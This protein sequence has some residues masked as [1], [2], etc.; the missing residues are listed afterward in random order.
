M[1]ENRPPIGDNELSEKD[2]QML[3]DPGDVVHEQIEPEKPMKFRACE[4]DWRNS[5]NAKQ[6][7]EALESEY[8]SMP[9]EMRLL[10]EATDATAMA[11][12]H[13]LVINSSFPEDFMKP[14]PFEDKSIDLKKIQ[15]KAYESSSQYDHIFNGYHPHGK[16]GFT[17]AWPKVLD[18]VRTL[19]TLDNFKG[20]NKEQMKLAVERIVDALGKKGIRAKGIVDILQYGPTYLVVLNDV[21]WRIIEQENLAFYLGG[22]M[23]TSEANLHHKNGGTI[24]AHEFEHMVNDRS[25]R[26]WSQRKRSEGG[27]K[28]DRMIRALKSELDAWLVT[29][30]L[31]TDLSTV[32]DTLRTYYLPTWKEKYGEESEKSFDDFFARAADMKP[33]IIGT[34]LEMGLDPSNLSAYN[35]CLR[36]FISSLPDRKATIGMLGQ[37]KKTGVYEAGEKALAQAA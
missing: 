36:T 33:Y 12:Y 20:L 10:A 27:E 15:E 2:Q 6:D 17:N 7:K 1:Q 9:L 8:E 3:V 26:S 28:T 23:F 13:R 16:H 14:R 19:N 37:I 30:P 35:L 22:F 11:V 34:M 4:P 5:P 31:G 18:T 21:C 25:D 32:R 29:F 24:V